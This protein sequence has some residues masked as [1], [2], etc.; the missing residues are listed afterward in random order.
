ME[1]IE[2]QSG[3]KRG[4]VN[5]ALRQRALLLDLEVSQ[6][7]DAPKVLKM[8]VVLGDRTYYR[9]GRFSLG[10]A[11]SE[12]STL[13]TRLPM[14][15]RRLPCSRTKRNLW[16]GFVKA[17]QAFSPFYISC[18]LLRQMSRTPWPWGWKWFLLPWEGSARAGN[19]R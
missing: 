5:D 6:S 15:G 4:D 1:T 3:Q 9:S 11:L 13:V 7:V 10:D 14:R 8:G 12:L 19:K 17:S 16:P 2:I 18:W